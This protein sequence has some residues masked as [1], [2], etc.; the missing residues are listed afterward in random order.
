[1][2]KY[3]PKK[4]E[5]ICY[6]KR[7]ISLFL[8]ALLV[9]SF[10]ACG[11][12]SEESSGGGGN[13]GGGG[14]KKGPAPE[15]PKEYLEYVVDAKEI[16]SGVAEAVTKV[17]PAETKNESGVYAANAKVKVSVGE[18]IDDLI[19]EFDS[20]VGSYFGA[21]VG[22]F[23]DEFVASWLDNFYVEMDADINSLE[24]MQFIATCGLNDTK[25]A[26]MKMTLDLEDGAIYAEI[27]ELTNKV[28]HI[29]LPD[30]YERYSGQMFTML[31][32]MQ[33]AIPSKQVTEKLVEKYINVVLDE[34]TDVT[35]ETTEI[36]VDSLTQEV[37]ATT[38][39][40][41]GAMMYDIC[42]SVLTNISEDEDIEEIL[43]NFCDFANEQGD[44][45]LDTDEIY[46]ALDDIIDDLERNEADF[47]DMSTVEVVIYTTKNHDITG[48]SVTVQK[49]TAEFLF[50]EED[51]EFAMTFT[52]NNK[53]IF[54]GSGTVKNNILNG[55]MGDVTGLVE[56]SFKDFNRNKLSDG[57][58]IGNF[59]IDV[60]AGEL[61]D[62]FGGL[63]GDSDVIDLINDCD[64]NLDFTDNASKFTLIYDDE[65][66]ISIGFEYNERNSSKIN[67]PSKNLVNLNDS[68]DAE[69]FLQSMNFDKLISNLKKAGVPNKLTNALE[70]MLDQI[71]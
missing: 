3:L 26:D 11:K 27:P 33:S 12:D 69:D 62:K 16:S 49:D 61:G 59:T 65:D 35:K 13:G 43:D 30:G 31:E 71:A 60:D 44:A 37:T 21:G 53:E 10:A 46:D 40:V 6:M 23:Y 24:L 2:L 67:V 41:D 47:E 1:M 14:N 29:P 28:V 5:R 25:I 55:K 39:T 15:D 58:L 63:L 4:A 34:I 7:F 64:I 20:S 50:V 54:N 51:G 42:H 17:A 56:I 19:P 32:A 66:A 52:A 18:G 70:D 48:I 36:S 9:L 45:N 8:T 22:D 68:D 57:K 38:F